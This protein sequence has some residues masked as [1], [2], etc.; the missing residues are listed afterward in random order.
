MTYTY[1]PALIETGLLA[2]V[3]TT[4]FVVLAPPFN[5]KAIPGMVKALLA[6][7]LALAVTPSLTK[8]ST[9]STGQFLMA[10]GEQVLIGA[11]LG[12]LVYVVFAAVQSAGNLIDLFGGF[13]IAQAFDPLAMVS[14]AQFARLYGWLAT[15]LLFV[16]DGYRI[17]IGGL[18]RSFHALPVGTSL[19]VGTLAH[20]LIAITSNMFLSA[21]QIAGPMVVVLVLAD[22]ALGLLT[23]AAPALNAFALGFPLKILLTLSLVSLTLLALPQIVTTL[24][25]QSFTNLIRTVTG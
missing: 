18:A 15:V 10:A 16:S 7:A 23:R 8:V 2:M 24:S 4:L 11:G 21:L 25:E 17:V 9:T 3:R 5:N 14:G 12:F 22:A 19:N 20:Q 13:Q 6:F 1:D